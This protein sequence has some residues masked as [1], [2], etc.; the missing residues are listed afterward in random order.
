MMFLRWLLY[1]FVFSKQDRQMY[2]DDMAR[3]YS[4]HYQQESC[5]ES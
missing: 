4:D 3:H 5:E 1:F 2:L